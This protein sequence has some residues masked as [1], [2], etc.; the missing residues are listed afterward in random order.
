VDDTHENNT[1]RA[2]IVSVPFCKP[3]LWRLGQAQGITAVLA[4]LTTETGL[5]GVGE[6][7]CFFPPAEAVKAVM[8]ACAPFVVGEDPFDHERIYKRILSLNSLYY[9]RVFARL[10]DLPPKNWTS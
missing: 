4:E 8:D 1:L 6:S 9:D 7:P 2:T 3:Y 5:V 10:A